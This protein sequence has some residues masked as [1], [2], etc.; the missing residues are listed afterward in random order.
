MAI[1]A[2]WRDVAR[3]LAIKAHD[4]LVLLIVGTALSRRSRGRRGGTLLESRSLGSGFSGLG[5]GFGHLLM[6]PGKLLK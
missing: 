4:G 5:H 3:L 6:L 1:R 2:S